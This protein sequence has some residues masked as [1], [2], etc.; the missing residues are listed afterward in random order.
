MNSTAE[1]GTGVGERRGVLFRERRSSYE[2]LRRAKSILVGIAAS[3][4]GRILIR[5]LK[6]RRLVHRD[7]ETASVA[8]DVISREYPCLATDGARRRDFSICFC[9]IGDALRRSSAWENSRC[10]LKISCSVCAVTSATPSRTFGL[11]GTRRSR[12]NCQRLVEIRLN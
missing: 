1:R 9:Q 4:L 2:F 11:A 5:S 10:W 6:A 8:I 7:C 12:R 3:L